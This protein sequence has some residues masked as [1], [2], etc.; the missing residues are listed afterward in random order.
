M[1]RRS[2]GRVYQWDNLKA[3]LILLV[4]VG[5]LIDRSNNPSIFLLK[6][7]YWIYIF[8]M[9]AF[10]FISG[11]FSKK[12][13]DE[14]RFSKIFRFL[15]WYFVLKIIF[16]VSGFA[17]YHEANFS[18]FKESGLPWYC[19]AIFAFQLISIYLVRYDRFLIL[20]LLVLIGCFAGYD[21]GLGDILSLAR[22]FTYFPFFFAGYLVDLKMMISR[23]NDFRIKIFAAI[24]L[25]SSFLFVFFKLYDTP[26]E[27]SFFT[28]R[29]AYANINEVIGLYGGL[30]RLIYYFF[31]FFIIVCLVALTTNKK[32]IATKFGE[33]SLI[34]Y[35]LHIPIVRILND[36]F[37]L[38]LLMQRN[39]IPQ[40]LTILLISII[41][42]IICRIQIVQTIMNRILYFKVPRIKQR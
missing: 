16:F 31:V 20:G 42:C 39:G 30:F 26:I 10:I 33:I 14:R 24:V 1:L 27:M 28:G 25:L 21:T 11:V 6:V 29:T 7:D 12:N 35:I 23:L 19:L 41:I 34:I 32:T 9:P 13:I 4:V 5:H 36:G 18:F 2:N 40:G 3:L 17:S 37:H 15:Q 8:H 22:I 38:D